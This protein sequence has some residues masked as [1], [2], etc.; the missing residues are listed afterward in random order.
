MKRFIEIDIDPS[1]CSIRHHPGWSGSAF[2][3]DQHPEARYKNGS[4]IYKV[5]EDD[6]GDETPLGTGGIVLGSI[7]HPR[8]SYCAYFVE[9]DNKP[10]YAMFVVEWKIADRAGRK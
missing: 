2:T 6:D 9:W 8:K 1:T 3:R 4:R 7:K 5:D 10:R